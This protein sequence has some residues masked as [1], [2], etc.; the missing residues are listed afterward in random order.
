MKK[1]IG[2]ILA[3]AMILTGCSGNSSNASSD[4]SQQKYK[5]QTL[6]LYTWG[7]YTGENLIA[8][9]EKQTGANV[10]IEY[11]DS[12]E[13]MY[14]KVMAGDTY[15]VVIPSDYMIERMIAEDLLLKLDKSKITNMDSLTDG[16][17]NLSFDMNNDYSIPYLWG[18]V[19]I[20]YNNKNV[21]KELVEE[22]GYEIL[23][24]ETYKGN[25]YMYDSERDS[26]MV[27]FKAL[28]YSMN[29]ENE[30]EIQKA[31]EW[32]MELNKNMEPAYVTDEVID[33]MINGSKDLAV[34]Y[35]GDATVVLDENEDMSFSTPKEGT[36]IWCDSMV[37]PKNA[38]NPA[39]AHE[40]I[41]Y[42]MTYDAAYD[43]SQT[44]G[45]AS[46][47]KDVLANMSGEGGIYADNE[48]FLPRAG[49]EKDETFEHNEVLKRK[50]SELWIK[51]KATK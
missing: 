45:Y 29:T 14:T 12:N 16:V 6:K 10:I 18:S 1:L 9:F 23:K 11:F 31:Y 2:I 27:A 38:E 20:V 41:N 39:L 51:V 49:Y 28:G 4:A 47:N 15:D 40:F 13:M 36:N 44:V 30:E 25:I 19:G 33:G 42:V 7:E 43:N 8:N 34:V 5:D 37:I 48:A 17:K 32:L 35:S 26:F 3:S 21:P 24:D 22:K 46:P 50:L